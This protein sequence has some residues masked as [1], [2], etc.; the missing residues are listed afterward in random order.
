MA[1]K[2][3]VESFLE[4]LAQCDVQIEEIEQHMGRSYPVD[5]AIAACPIVT[6]ELLVILAESRDSV[7]RRNVICNAAIPTETLIS[8]AKEFPSEFFSHPL[9]NLLILEDPQL[10]TRLEP[11][12][13][14]SFLN[15][16]ECPDSFV[17]WAC[18]H[19]CKTD[20]LEILK[21][22]DL[23][24]SQLRIIARS[25]HPKPAERAIDRLIEMGEAW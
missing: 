25:A 15:N 4:K 12:V 11:G 14:K 1:K 10:L 16:P 22:P 13:L 5:R 3:S 7:T 19:G 8:L 23:S 2:I 24:V 6:S 17:Q 21:R 9:L 18:Q 20:Q